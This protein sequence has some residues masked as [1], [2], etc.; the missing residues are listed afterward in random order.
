MAKCV[1][2]R[3][4]EAEKSRAGEV[5]LTNTKTVPSVRVMTEGVNSP[6]SLTKVLVLPVTV[7]NEIALRLR[8][9]QNRRESMSALRPRQYH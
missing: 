7:I 6:R 8:N 5:S 1:R 3:I 9:S 2:V 4:R